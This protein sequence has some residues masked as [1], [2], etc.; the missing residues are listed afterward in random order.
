MMTTEKMRAKAQ[1]NRIRRMAER[2][3]L[4]LVKSRRR[5]RYA[6]GYGTYS[7]VE[8]GDSATT[9]G[10]SLAQIEDILTGQNP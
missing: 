4:A 10:C 7:L 8:R 2:Q 1:E 3:G 5:D 6:T 9:F